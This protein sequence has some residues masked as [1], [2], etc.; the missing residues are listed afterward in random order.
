MTLIQTIYTTLYEL[1][2]IIQSI[3]ALVLDALGLIGL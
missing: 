1:A 3:V 2:A